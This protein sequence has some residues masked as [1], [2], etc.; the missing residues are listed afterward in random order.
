MLANKP[1][2]RLAYTIGKTRGFG[3]CKIIRKA[4]F[5]HTKVGHFSDNEH[6]TIYVDSAVKVLLSH[7]RIGSCEVIK[8]HSW[9]REHCDC[10]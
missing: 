6:R 4:D 7:I 10:T 1:I 3:K 5:E 9:I 8:L 2:P